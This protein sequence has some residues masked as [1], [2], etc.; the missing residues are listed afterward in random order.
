MNN[1]SIGSDNGLSPIRRQAII[2]T[3]ADLLS[4]WNLGTNF[5]KVLIKMNKRIYEYHYHTKMHLKMSP[6]KW[7]PFWPG[8]DE[9]SYHVTSL[10]G[11]T[12]CIT[13]IRYL[14]KCYQNKSSFFK[15]HL[16]FLWSA[17]NVFKEKGFY[18]SLYIVQLIALWASGQYDKLSS[19]SKHC[20]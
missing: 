11:S 1:V 5:S 6:A 13:G 15:R 2:W 9:L 10:H 7:R 8:G 4:V 3:N 17:W 14:S 12:F 16:D 20:N 19:T 18:K